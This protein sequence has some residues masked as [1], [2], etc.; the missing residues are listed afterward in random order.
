MKQKFIGSLN[1]IQKEL[2]TN[3]F[4]SRKGVESIVT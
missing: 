4:L 1:I 3:G 2:V